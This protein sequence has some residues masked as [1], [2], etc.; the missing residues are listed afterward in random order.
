MARCHS[1]LTWNVWDYEVSLVWEVW[2]GN[3]SVIWEWS[4]KTEFSNSNWSLY[5]RTLFSIYAG[6]N[7][8]ATTWGWSHLGLGMRPGMVWEWG[9]S[10][11][12]MRSESEGCL[13]PQWLWLGYR[14][15]P[16]RRWAEGGTHCHHTCTGPVLSSAH[17]LEMINHFKLK[18][19]YTAG[20]IW[21]FII[22]S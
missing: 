12:G 17:F 3:T 4:Q 2:S 1:R 9:W 14:L 13:P 6:A 11:L 21:K 10:N 22:S 15:A 7:W 8:E 19:N 18:K 5:Q 16:P 20:L